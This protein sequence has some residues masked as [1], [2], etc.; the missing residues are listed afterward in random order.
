MYF[1]PTKEATTYCEGWERMRSRAEAVDC[2][3]TVW[4]ALRAEKVDG[5]QVIGLAEDY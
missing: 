5:E 2:G 1:L 3:A 4:T